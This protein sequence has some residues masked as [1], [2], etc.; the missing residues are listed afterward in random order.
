MKAFSWAALFLLAGVGA[1]QAAELERS[2][3]AEGAF[4]GRG[5]QILRTKAFLPPDFDQE[6]FDNL[7]QS[8]EEPLR[9]QAAAASPDERRAM[10]FSRYGFTSEPGDTSGKP[11]QYTV[12]SQGNWTM[13]CLACHQGKAAGRVIPG[14]PNSHFALQTLVDDVRNTKLRIKKRLVRMD[15]ASAVLPL[16][17]SNGTTNAVV[18]GMALMASRDPELNVIQR[19]PPKLVHHDHDAPAWWNFKKKTHL[20]SDGFVGKNHR[21]LMQFML[22]PENGPEKFAEWESDFR[23]IYAWLESLSPPKYPFAIDRALAERGGDVFNTNCAECH[24]K[25]GRD[26]SYPNKIVA[27]EE[28]GTDPV[29]LNAL[30]VEHRAAYGASWFGHFGQDALVK[31]PG[32]YV[33]PPLDGIWASAPYLHNGSVPTLWHMLHPSERPA[34]WL[35]DEDGYDQEKVGLN[36]ATMKTV[37]AEIKLGSDRRK[38]FDVTATGKSAQGHTFPEALDEDEKR[39]VLEYLKTL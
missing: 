36:V 6:T 12:D 19:I 21:P 11:Q 32:G 2:Q 1:S 16:G 20:Y 8:W 4:S 37:P 3:A 38:Y 15:L 14:V 34:V 27:I 18:F 7:W 35:R 13:T 17:T 23:E 25:Y 22:I 29:R 24:G 31:D 10:A 30:T 26:A 5:Y 33:A 28:V 39:A 9:T